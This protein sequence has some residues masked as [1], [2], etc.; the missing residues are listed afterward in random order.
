MAKTKNFLANIKKGALHT[1]LGIPQSQKIPA[2]KEAIKKTDSPKLR[3][4]KQLA[5][6]MKSWNHKKK[7]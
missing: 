2:S 7:K 5:I 6:N 1:A 4:E 3:Q